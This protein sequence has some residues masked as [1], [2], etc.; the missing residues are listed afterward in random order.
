MGLFPPLFLKRRINRSLPGSFVK[1]T[2]SSPS[3]PKR[4]AQPELEPEPR[5]EERANG[6]STGDGFEKNLHTEDFTF[7]AHIQ[8]E[9]N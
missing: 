1:E 9:L 5:Q 7:G 2:I 6:R 8:L 3:K 4:R